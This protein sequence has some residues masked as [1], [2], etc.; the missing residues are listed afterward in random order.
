MNWSYEQHKH[1]STEH[2]HKAEKSRVAQSI[3]DEA[4]NAIEQTWGKR[5][6]RK[7]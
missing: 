4:R 6:R 3:I 1:Y 2:M 5:A 7:R